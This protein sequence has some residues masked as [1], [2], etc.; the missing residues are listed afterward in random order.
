MRIPGFYRLSTEDRGARVELS[1]QARALLDGGGLDLETAD[2]MIE[3]VVGL[4]ALPLGLALN[5]QVNG[6]D[7]LVPMAIEEPSVV[8][9]ASN[10][11]RLV[12]AG[13][14]FRAE[15]DPPVMTAQVQLVAVA[16]P[17]TA[18]ARIAEE[19]A[20]ILAEAE[21][22]SP[23]LRDRGGGPRDVSVR[24]LARPGEPDGGVIVVGIDVDC[25]DAMGAN[26][27]NSLAEALAPRLALLAGAR[28]G[29]RILSNLAD[30][31]CVRVAAR[32]PLDVLGGPEVRDGIVAASR[33]AELDPYRAATHDTGII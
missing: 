21:A 13:G 7:H 27:V 23:R 29:L 17:E 1:P 11:A 30:R 6:R 14:G 28:P 19:K 18:V 3:N 12:R 9:A 32:V 26:L 10:A 33:F 24:V 2:R 25:R 20:A 4:Y 22:L 15:A 8:A 31:R 16:D 5:F